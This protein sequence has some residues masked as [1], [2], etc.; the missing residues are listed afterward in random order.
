[1]RRSKSICADRVRGVRGHYQA[2]LRLSLCLCFLVCCFVLRHSVVSLVFSRS[3]V[4]VCLEILFLVFLFLCDLSFASVCFSSRVI[5]FLFSLCFFAPLSRRCAFVGWRAGSA[6]ENGP[7]PFAGLVSAVAL[8]VVVALGGRSRPRGLVPGRRS[9]GAG[10]RAA[11]RGVGGR[12]G[13]GRARVWLSAAGR[14]RAPVAAARR[15]GAR[16]RGA[17]PSARARGRA[18]ARARAAVR[19][20]RALRVSPR[21][22][23]P[24]VV[25]AR[26][27]A[28]P[29]LRPPPP[30]LPPP[31]PPPP[32][33]SPP[34]PPLPS[35]LAQ[36]HASLLQVTRTAYPGDRLRSCGTAMR[37]SKSIC[38]DRV[39]G[40][41][42][43][44]QARLGVLPPGPTAPKCPWLLATEFPLFDDSA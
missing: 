4:F 42:G 39:R 27:P 26:A 40:V 30:P 1:M 17:R 34:P 14:G 29:P 28:P 41:R 25:C 7:V 43:H 8:S 13:R 20:P 32:L 10:A 12:A 9:R 23:P 37:R 24:C 3:R 11:E 15:R 21:L 2:R 35:P 22:A 18:R 19:R 38:A 16:S 6:V 33:P 44:Y 31:P 36:P 5:A